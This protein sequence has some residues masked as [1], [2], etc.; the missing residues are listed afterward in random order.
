MLNLGGYET[1]QELASSGL[2]TVYSARRAGTDEPPA[3]V[4][5]LCAPNVDVLG[6]AA[7][8]AAVAAFLGRARAQQQIAQAMA[9]TPAAGRFAKVHAMGRDEQAGGAFLVTDLGDKGSMQKLGTGRVTLDA[10]TMSRLVAEVVEALAELDR[11]LNRGHGDLKPSNILLTAAGAGGALA[12]LSRARVLLADPLDPSASTPDRDRLS[13]LRAVGGLVHL[14]VLHTPFRG[15]WPLPASPEWGALGSAGPGWLELVNKLLD[16]SD[17]APRP[18]IAELGAILA[19]LRQQ[20]KSRTPMY[21]ALAVALLLAGGATTFVLTR[22]AKP[23]TKTTLWS[24]ATEERWKQLCNAHRGWFSLFRAGLSK[25][26]GEGV[27]IVA[28]VVAPG[29]PA[30]PTAVATRRDAYL[31]LDPQLAAL[32]NLPGAGDGFDPWSIAKGS[33]AAVKPERDLNDLARDPGIYARADWGVGRTEEALGAIDALRKGLAQWQAPA[34][35]AASAADYRQRGW[36]KPA[37]YLERLGAGIKPEQD[38]DVVATIDAVLAARAALA[39]VDAAWAKVQE[40]AGKLAGAPEPILASFA[41]STAAIAGGSGAAGTSGTRDD[42]VGL[43]TRV[44]SLA[45]LA[46][47]LAD[48]AQKDLA[49]TDLDAFTSSEAY[50]ALRDAKASEERFTGYLAQAA[51]FPNL[52]PASDPRRAV[53]LSKQAD[54]VSAQAARLASRPLQVRLDDGLSGRLSRLV[55]DVAALAPE[56]L[57]WNR[58]NQAKVESE[59][60]RIRDEIAALDSTLKEKITTRLAEIAAAAREVRDTLA[61]RSAVVEGSDAANAA[62]RTWRD[63]LLKSLGSDEQYE[64]LRDSAAA[65][66]AALNQANTAVAPGF[67]AVN[68]ASPVEAQL[69][70]AA[71]DERERLLGSW[72]A[73]VGQTPPDPAAVAASAAKPAREF[74]ATLAAL[75]T[76]RD[77]LADVE[78]R[79]AQGV[80]PGEPGDGAALDAAWTKAAGAP[81]TALAG[82]RPALAGLESRLSDAKAISAQRDRA[83]LFRVIDEAR[84]DRPERALSAWKRLGEPATAWPASVADLAQAAQ[85]RGKLDATLA[86]V[87]ESRRASLAQQV[88]SEFKSRWSA[89]ALGLVEPRGVE[90]ALDARA[91]FGVTDSD[92]PPRLAF[93]QLVRD[94]RT[95]TRER[96]MTDDAVRPLVAAF[97][98]KTAALSGDVSSQA[99]ASRV[100]AA[101][102]PMGFVEERREPEID[103]RTLGPGKVWGVQSASVEG[104]RLVFRKGNLRLEFVRVEAPEAPVFL[105]TQE[106]SIGDA[107]DIAQGPAAAQFKEASALQDPNVAIWTGP[108]GWSFTARGELS[109]GTWYKNDP[110][111]TPELP[112]YAP[113][114]LAPGQVVRLAEAAGGEP[115]REHP[116]QSISPV[117]LAVLAR[118]VGCRFPTPGEWQAAYQLLGSSI[119]AGANLR[120]QAWRTQQQHVDATRRQVI[121][122]DP[123]QWPDAGAFTPESGKPPEGERATSRPSADGTLWFAKVGSGPGPVHHLVGNVAELTFSDWYKL[124]TVAPSAAAIATLFDAQMDALGII[125]GS[126]LSAPELPIDRPLPVDTITAEEGY[127]DMGARLAFSGKGTKPPKQP[128]ATQVQAVLTDEAYLLGR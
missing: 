81:V 99:T 4:V 111:F 87:K 124:E 110:I 59:T 31:S 54:G 40:Q 100:R 88:A 118:S 112:G 97:L 85:L 60:R 113:T 115:T 73:S 95:Q 45:T 66:A 69:A 126:A 96:T 80:V 53:D 70:R 7:T 106:I 57:R 94:L 79:L 108:R 10:S 37:A 23:D 22:E 107:I 46:A 77:E 3:F 16:P 55:P 103:P 17:T 92:L 74:Q 56:R 52:D 20:K 68:A 50:L 120:D 48:F 119:P 64:T 82:V 105:C 8:E 90:A 104:D 2:V 15:G 13:D 58:R 49:G 25:K 122:K 19:Q 114:T 109:V 93:N 34:A 26:P 1:V 35:L 65:L 127:A 42:L 32:V 14:L 33:T 86:G 12:D 102:T 11:A 29:A 18:S 67:V 47:R 101:L 39:R 6:E 83:A 128:L 75:A 125:G 21:I 117:A 71:A 41:S 123:Y 38:A 27:P 91:D 98:Q 36:E 24:P 89:L 116:M 72:L 84:A 51:K 62:W 30:A 61:A 121:R 76:L 63:A 78:D 5:K 44:E 9:A 28:P 43:A